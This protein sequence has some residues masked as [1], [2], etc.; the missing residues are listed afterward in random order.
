MKLSLTLLAIAAASA[1]AK[2][3]SLTPENYDAA[4]AGKTV[5]IK[6][7]AP[8]CGHCKTMAPHWEKLAAEWEGNAI[9]LIAEVDCTV[10][11]SRALCDGNGVKGFP[12]LKW[13]AP[14]ALEDYAGGR[15]Y[16]DFAKFATENLKPVCS[17]AQIDLCDD[18]KKALIQSLQA[19]SDD[20]L[21]T[22][23]KAAEDLM[24]NAETEFS[25]A[26][27][28]LQATYEAL[29]KTKEDK[30]NE[31]KNSGLTLM[32]AVLKSKEGGSDEL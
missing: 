1:D 10:E 30:E 28:E 13:G 6:F 23:I 19:Q 16:D 25:A 2:V 8:W 32:K 27:E 22:Q 14:D 9:G 20:A 26:V 5:F 18:D 4:T 12:T 21:K 31:V 17:V 24:E 29:M 7:F 15:E 11:D 3:L